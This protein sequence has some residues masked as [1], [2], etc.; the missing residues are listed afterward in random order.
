MESM[1]LE[2]VGMERA[3]LLVAI[4]ALASYSL[5]QICKM[6]FKD[7][8][9]RC[10]RRRRIALRMVSVILGGTFGYTLAGHTGF[11]AIIGVGAGSLTTAVFSGIKARIKTMAR[12]RDDF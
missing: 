9:L 10:P 8:A 4:S 5:T 12:E 1:T 11:G 7:N 3:V 6:A 2:N